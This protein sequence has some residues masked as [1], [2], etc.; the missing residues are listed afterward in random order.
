MAKLK[1]PFELEKPSNNEYVT[2]ASEIGHGNK[3]VAEELEQLQ[4]EGQAIVGSDFSRFDVTKGYISNTG[5][6]YVENNGVDT[7]G[8]IP[9]KQFDVFEYS[10]RTNAS[11][12]NVWG[13]AT[14][15]LINPVKLLQGSDEQQNNVMF[16]IPAGVNYIRAL[17]RNSSHQSTPSELKIIKRED[18]QSF[19]PK[20][21]SDA[22][23]YHVSGEIRVPS[24]YTIA[25]CSMPIPAPQEGSLYVTGLYAPNSSAFAQY[26]ELDIEGN[27]IQVHTTSSN[28]TDKSLEIAASSLNSECAFVAFNTATS[29]FFCVIYAT[30]S[31]LSDNSN[32]TA[33]LLLSIGNFFKEQTFIESLEGG[34]EAEKIYETTSRDAGR[35]PLGFTVTTGDTLTIS[36]DTDAEGY[37]VNLYLFLDSSTSPAIEVATGVQQGSVLNFAVPSEVNYFKVVGRTD[38]NAKKVTFQKN[39]TKSILDRVSDLEASGTEEIEEIQDFLEPMHETSEAEKSYSGTNRDSGRVALGFSATEGDVITVTVLEEAQTHTVNLYLFYDGSTSTAI[40]VK[41][42]ATEGEKIY[43]PVPSEVNYFKVVAAGSGAADGYSRKALWQKNVKPDITER[44]DILEESSDIVNTIENVTDIKGSTTHGKISESGWT[45]SSVTTADI[46]GF[47]DVKPGDVILYSGRVAPNRYNDGRDNS[48]VWGFDA[49]TS[50]PN[51]GTMVRL[52]R[53]GEYNR[54]EIIIP[55]GINYIRAWSYN[56]SH[57]TTPSKLELFR[58]GGDMSKLKYKRYIVVDANGYGDYTSLQDAIE[59]SDD[60]Y[61]R[62]NSKD[63]YPIPTVIVVMPGVYEMDTLTAAERDSRSYRNLAIVGVDKC[64]CVI[65]NHKGY[66]ATDTYEDNAPLILSG[67][68]YIANLTVI[69]TSEDYDTYYPATDYQRSNRCY[70]IHC[71]GNAYEGSVVEIHNCI[72]KNDHCACVGIGLRAGMEARITDCIMET[73]MDLT[74]NVDYNAVVQ[75]HDGGVSTHPEDQHITIKNCIIKN[76]TSRLAFRWSV[77]SNGAP[78]LVT[79]VNNVMKTTDNAN[80]LALGTLDDVVFLDDVNYGNNINALNTL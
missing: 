12:V 18:I 14:K 43:F 57:A 29:N 11:M 44:V 41:S 62:P 47:V 25:R 10:G 32:N 31:I 23:Y 3:S 69:A 30:S 19:V 58:I 7:T 6:S 55:Q 79:A 21:V 76:K 16:V 37:G 59:A 80:C 27:V 36:V 56:E 73:Q 50:N 46:T 15:E 74:N 77:I 1:L 66:Y 34:N 54:K 70:C 75:G 26:V 65:R 48:G 2:Q 22:H 52:L 33:Q 8:Y 64:Q 51:T 35:Q 45:D 53:P 67:N 71:D 72:L 68:I 20:I 78:S 60:R 17:S 24:S 40:P 38:G 63:A 39:V 5:T 9:V 42:G 4:Q 49:K 61:F 13:Y 28:Y